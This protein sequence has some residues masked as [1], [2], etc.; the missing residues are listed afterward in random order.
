M[1]RFWLILLAPLLAWAQVPPPQ[2]SGVLLECDRNVATG[3]LAVRAADNQVYRFQFDARTFVERD[4]FTGT[5]TRLVAGDKVDVESDPVDG[6]LLR[7]A[8]TIR[9]VVPKAVPR[10]NLAEVR[11]RSSTSRL[12]EVLLPHETITFAGV[13]SRLNSQSLILHT[14]TGE[15]TVLIRKD[16]RY[17]DNGDTV[18][19]ADLQPNMRVFVRAARNL[20]EQVEAYQ[21]IWGK[22]MEPQRN[23]DKHR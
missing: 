23:A 13:V 12:P 8:R 1:R 17:I 7:Y 2:M 18:E 4:S 11:E 9:V 19:A 22:I 16:T 6:S 14:R 15:Q 10:M 5:V 20:Y 3:E 21:V